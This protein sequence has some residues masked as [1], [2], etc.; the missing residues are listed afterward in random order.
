MSLSVLA[1]DFTSINPGLIFWTLV[2][3]LCV[4]IVLRWKAWGPV[5]TLVQE[6]EKQIQSAIDSAKRERA[7]AEKLLAEQKS[8]A[9]EARKEAAEMMRRHQA[10][11]EKFREELMAKAKKDADELMATNRRQI[12]D[13]KQKAIAEVQAMSVDLAIEIAAKLLGERLDEPKHRKLAEQF[14]A[15]LPKNGAPAQPRI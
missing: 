11:V 15:E 3:F 4:F 13:Q 8:A 6:R 10:E 5:L 2:T 14:I 12:E 1:A 7:E 9:A